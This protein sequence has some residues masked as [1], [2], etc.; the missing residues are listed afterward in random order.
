MNERI[1]FSQIGALVDAREDRNVQHA[2][3]NALRGI[4]HTEQ[5]I[6]QRARSIRSTL[7]LIEQK[8]DAHLMLNPSGELQSQGPELD[9]LIAKNH[10]HWETA[11]ALLTPD[12]LRSIGIDVK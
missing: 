6:R 9:L 2:L 8:L 12:E 5:S 10:L 3:E 1:S 7:D 11:G 4:N